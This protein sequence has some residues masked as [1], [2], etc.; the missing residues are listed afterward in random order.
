MT[1]CLPPVC[2]PYVYPLFLVWFQFVT[3]YPNFTQCLPAGI[4][5]LCGI[6]I[7]SECDLI[8]WKCIQVFDPKVLLKNPSKYP[9]VFWEG[10]L[11]MMNIER[12]QNEKLIFLWLIE[13]YDEKP[14]SW[15]VHRKY[16]YIL[17]MI[18]LP[19][20]AGTSGK[21]ITGPIDKQRG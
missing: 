19:G 13:I 8:Q 6:M 11:M 21:L 18:T 4:G 7:S 20:L 16:I 3:D 5:S 1:I 12:F 17:P 10:M 15:T 9:N 14:M 2:I